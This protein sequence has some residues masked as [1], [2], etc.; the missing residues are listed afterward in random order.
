M[1]LQW[2]VQ[3]GSGRATEGDH[4]A[5]AAWRAACPEHEAAAREAEALWSGIGLAGGEARQKI[6]RGRIARRTL[7]SGLG[8]GLGL[9]LWGSGVIGP[10]LFADHR[11]ATGERRQ[12]LLADGS[13][14]L[15]NAASALSVDFSGSARHLRLWH[16]QATFTVAH[17]PGRPF[18]VRA[19]QGE[20]RAI[21][22]VFDVDMRQV[23]VVVTVLEGIVGVQTEDLPAPTRLIANQSA[24]YGDSGAVGPGRV[25]DADA[26]TAWRRG[27][28]VFNGRR[29][30]DV[31]AEISRQQ[32]GHILVASQSARDLPVTGSFSLTDPEAILEIIERTLPIRVTRLPMLTIIR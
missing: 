19:G 32:G 17:D 24:E 3:L 23:S 30:G 31:I 26:E 27:R 20:A 15:L 5:Y 9:G 25:V 18:I 4:R 21:G 7:L 28:L 12:I 22:T 6:Q 8:M 10:H 2:L 14:V 1:A 11:T 16:G 29:L 13:E